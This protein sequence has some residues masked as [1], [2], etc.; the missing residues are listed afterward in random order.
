MGLD[1]LLRLRRDHRATADFLGGPH[2]LE[3]AGHNLAGAR[4][5][6]VIRRLR[7]EELGIREDD[8]ELIVQAVEEETQL[9]RFVHWSPRGECRDVVD[10]PPAGH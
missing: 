10:V 5:V 6:N 7:F 8:A 1:A 3:R 4:A 2:R 9:W